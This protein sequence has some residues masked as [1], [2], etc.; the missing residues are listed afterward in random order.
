MR[1]RPVQVVRLSGGMVE[2]QEKRRV[3]N[4]FSFSSLR[5]SFGALARRW[6]GA[7]NEKDTQQWVRLEPPFQIQPVLLPPL[8]ADMP[9]RYASREYALSASPRDSIVAALKATRISFNDRSSAWAVGEAMRQ[10]SRASL[11]QAT[12]R[13]PMQDG[14]GSAFLQLARSTSLGEADEAA[15]DLSAASPELLFT[16]TAGGGG[17]AR[18]ITSVDSEP[19]ASEPETACSAAV[20]ERA[21]AER[22][23]SIE[24][25]PSDE[26]PPRAAQPEPQQPEP[27]WEPASVPRLSSQPA[28]HSARSSSRSPRRP[29]QPPQLALGEL[30]AKGGS[31]ASVFACDF[32]GAPM[33]VKL[34]NRAAARPDQ[35]ETMVAEAELCR[36]L[37][38]PMI[39][40]FVFVGIEMGL[41]GSGGSHIG[42]V[43]EV[44]AAQALPFPTPPPLTS[45]P[46]P[47]PRGRRCC[48]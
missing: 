5:Q 17:S 15:I 16:L 21:F 30:L 34:M 22:A 35:V 42:I 44:S 31:G 10:Q 41:A 48:R 47:H 43:M 46:T 39:V 13:S 14:H 9:G 7:R 33:A 25:G 45:N 8:S 18:S 36:R 3:A 4:L 37:H 6:N 28:T 40:R 19:R 29:S 12:P 23:F 38:H 26:P 24:A 1:P 32:D 11:R 2:H 27:P 20:T